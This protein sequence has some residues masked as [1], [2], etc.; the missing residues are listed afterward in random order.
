MPTVG[1]LRGGS[2]T[3]EATDLT[4]GALLVF[5]AR[6][7]RPGSSVAIIVVLVL[8]A[9]HE[10]SHDIGAD[11]EAIHVLGVKLAFHGRNGV[12]DRER[13]GD[14]DGVLLPGEAV[15]G[16]LDCDTCQCGLACMHTNLSGGP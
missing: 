15:E 5:R 12:L 1:Q 11:R 13:L 2:A 14:L 16:D 8:A 7:V 10:C 4:K 3:S 6:V 9:Q